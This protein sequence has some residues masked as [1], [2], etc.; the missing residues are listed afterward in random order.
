MELTAAIKALE[1]LEDGSTVTLRS[2][3]QYLIK[4][5]NEWMQDYKDRNWR[6]VEGSS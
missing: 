2:D 5:M 4:S 1:A 6:K 3:S